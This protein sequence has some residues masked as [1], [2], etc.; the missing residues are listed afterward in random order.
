MSC[1]LMRTREEEEEKH[2]GLGYEKKGILDFR[3][4]DMHDFHPG[5]YLCLGSL[6]RAQMVAQLSYDNVAG[7][8]VRPSFST[9][10]PSQNKVCRP[11]QSRFG[12]LHKHDRLRQAA[13]QWRL[14]I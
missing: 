11:S 9:E 4:E 10:L 6:C 8:V 1:N 5:P 13:G 12:K 2:P 3:N 14:L 7:I